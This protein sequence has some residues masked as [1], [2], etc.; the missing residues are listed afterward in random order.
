MK[1]GNSHQVPYFL[2][3]KPPLR[4]DA[5]FK[6]GKLSNKTKRVIEFSIPYKKFA[7]FH[8][9]NKILICTHERYMTQKISE[10][11]NFS[12]IN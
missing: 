5:V 10:P 8:L 12:E 9:L 11:S 7:T 2:V 1:D 3:L 4:T 6:Q